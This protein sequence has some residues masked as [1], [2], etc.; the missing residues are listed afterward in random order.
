MLIL[1]TVHIRAFTLSEIII[2]IAIAGVMVVSL[3][4]LFL[5]TS[6][7]SNFG[8]NRVRATQLAESEMTL[9]K[10]AG[11]PQLQALVGTATPNLDLEEGSVA[12]HR[13][14]RVDSLGGA[15]AAMLKITVLVDWKERRQMEIQEK[16]AAADEA[17]GHLELVSIV[18]PEASY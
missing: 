14:T 17:S 13:H 8:L 7:S 15:D 1:S 16:R 18:A 3:L 11:Y 5:L 12:F 6:V 9:R 10:L 2:A 4:G